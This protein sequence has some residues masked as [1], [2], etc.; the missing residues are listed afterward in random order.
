MATRGVP[1]TFLAL[2]DVLVEKIGQIYDTEIRKAKTW[3]W[4]GPDEIEGDSELCMYDIATAYQVSV[5]GF[6]SLNICGWTGMDLFR[7]ESMMIIME[8]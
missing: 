6:R 2:P 4:W 3:Y 7:E 5:N 1:K 8:I